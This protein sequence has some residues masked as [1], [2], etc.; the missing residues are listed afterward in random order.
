MTPRQAPPANGACA[1][2][3]RR[4]YY[5]LALAD[6][7]IYRMFHDPSSERWFMDGMYD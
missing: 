6:G 4:D 3:F 2:G 7:G 1:M 5:E